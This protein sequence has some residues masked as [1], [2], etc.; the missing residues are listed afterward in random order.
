MIN[1]LILLKNIDGGTGTY[2]EGLLEIKKLYKESELNINVLVIDA[3][4]FRFENMVDSYFSEKK[5]NLSKYNFS[6][7]DIVSFLKEIYWFKQ[8]ISVFEPDVVISS[9]SHSIFISEISK[10]LFRKNFKNISMIHN[11]IWK[12]I[13]FKSPK[14]L[15]NLI[16]FF[17]S[18]FINRSYLVITV[19]KRLSRDVSFFL[20]LKKKPETIQ[21][22]I[23]SRFHT[24]K[25]NLRKKNNNVVISVARFDRQK[26]HKTL[27]MAFDIVSKKIPN[28]ELWLVGDGPLENEL[29][30]LATSLHLIDRVMFLGWIQNPTSLIDKSDLFVLSTHW[31]GFPLSM[32]EA[33][34]RG[35][36]VIASNCEY[37]PFEIVGH[38]KYGILAPL[39]DPCY[40]A[41][42][43][44]KI[45][46][47]KKIRDRYSYLSYKR[48]KD[49]ILKHML[50][51]YKKII[52]KAGN[53]SLYPKS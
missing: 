19:S 30:K 50:L 2:L 32:L 38:N 28:A 10:M 14:H 44:I 41:N 15:H 17:L 36:P 6:V 25:P 47:N 22:L 42:S 8:E 11:N 35:V 51:K 37:G 27:L 13:E 48:S 31:E 29:K 21:C 53:T 18:F 3:P 34:M 20:R 33:M 26:D 16:R 7:I 1:L 45:L 12:V 40:L 46:S 4:N 43:I 39:D 49:F 52:D 5:P 24:K 9:D 23:P